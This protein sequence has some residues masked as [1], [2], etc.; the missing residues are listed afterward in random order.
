MLRF[1]HT[2]LENYSNVAINDNSLIMDGGIWQN[3]RN[4]IWTL[5]QKQ[6]HLISLVPVRNVSSELIAYGYQDNEANRELRMLKELTET[7]HAL[8]FTDIFPE[9]KEVIIG[10]G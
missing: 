7:E 4:L 1:Y 6:N 3:C 2:K 9:Y 10:G 8:Q 5:D